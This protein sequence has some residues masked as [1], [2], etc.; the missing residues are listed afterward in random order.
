MDIPQPQA[1]CAALT[2]SKDTTFRDYAQG[3]YRMRGIGTGQRIELFLIPEVSS[4]IYDA[5][6]R[7]AGQSRAGAWHPKYA[8]PGAPGG[9]A[10]PLAPPI[11]IAPT[12]IEPSAAAPP[13]PA[14]TA[15]PQVAAPIASPLM[16]GEAAVASNLVSQSLWLRRVSGW[17]HLNSMRSERTQ[18]LL[19]AEQTLANVWRKAAYAARSRFTYDLG[20]FYL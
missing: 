7:A 13:P 9:V 5:T 16:A 19:L 10:A 20:A 1:A 15:A 3:A 2:L 17:L 8:A 18:F 4:L 6:A 14:D 11:A 12:P